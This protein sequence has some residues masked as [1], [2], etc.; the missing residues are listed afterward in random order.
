MRTDINT[1]CL[2]G[3]GWIGGLRCRCRD[4]K[5]PPVSCGTNFIREE[6]AEMVQCT[7][8]WHYHA[9]NLYCDFIDP[10]STRDSFELCFVALLPELP[11]GCVCVTSEM[12]MAHFRTGGRSRAYRV[13]L[14]ETS[15]APLVLQP[16]KQCH[17]P[18]LENDCLRQDSFLSGGHS[19]GEA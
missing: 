1:L 8:F 5:L 3:G 9:Q 4:R 6:H 19:A 7:T 11:L 10:P 12:S 16:L 17:D 15:E 2:M 18:P 14:N 13:G